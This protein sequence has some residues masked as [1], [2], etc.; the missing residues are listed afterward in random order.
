MTE[1]KH[2]FSKVKIGN[3]IIKNRILTT[4]HQTNHVKDG[5]PTEDFDAY[6]EERAKGGLG[7]A[8]IEAAAVHSSGLLT[9]KTIM[10]YDERVI[11]AYKRFVKKVNPHGMKVFA[12]LFHGGREV[13]SSEYRNAALAPS[14]VPSLRYATMPRPM[15]IEEIEDVIEGF[16]ISA[17]NAKEGGLDGVEICCS[18]GYLPSQF[19]SPHTNLRTDKYGGSFKNRMRFVVEIID[20]VWEAVGEDFTVGIR[21]SS[22][23]KTMDGTDIKDAI[24]IVEYLSEKVRLDFIDVT[25]GDS[26]TFTGST[27]IAPPSPM[28]HAYLSPDAFKI[29]MAG[30]IPVFISNRI[31]DPVDGE[32]IISSGKA[33]MVAMTRATIVDP[34]MPNKAKNGEL[35]QIDACLGCLQA[36]IGHYH[37]GLAIGCIQNPEAGR[38]RE[39]NALYGKKAVH[40]KVLVIGAGPGGLEAAITADKKGHDVTLVD[41]SDCIGGMLNTMRKAPMR[42]EMAESMLDNYFK[43]LELSNVK[44]ELNR[45]ITKE[46][47]SVINPD[48]IICA[49]GSSVYK[50]L[51]TGMNDERIIYIDDLF[52]INQFEKDEKV[53]VFDFG[54]EWSGVEGAIH[55]AENGCDVTLITARLYAAENVHQYLR[56]E[57][58]KRLNEL[59]ITVKAQHDFGGIEDKSVIVRNL[60]TN[61]KMEESYSK[62]VLALGRVPVRDLYEELKHDYET[63]QIGDCSAPRTIE[64]ATYEGLMTSL[65]LPVSSKQYMYT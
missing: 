40:K 43:Q 30:A 32:K 36:C 59:N 27:H 63:H 5:I 46:N 10:A 48:V 3:T 50:P 1:F 15:S 42:R 23:E 4:A 60:F 44:V 16:A 13:V 11:D 28:K 52:N 62:V 55:L 51:Y 57:Y 38:E 39:T 18:H 24:K 17:V 20:R 6:H 19:W 56:N 35:R 9:T 41:K 54:G 45:E 58:I 21:M 8:I 22:D 26:S 7:L 29:R 2:L 49:L 31:M 34:H 47:V 61:K 64:E 37:K 25:A 12:Q 53:A 33:D 65:N 14:A